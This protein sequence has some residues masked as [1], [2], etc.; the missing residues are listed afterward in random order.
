MGNISSN[1]PNPPNI[2][3]SI[4]KSRKFRDK[5]HEE[6]ANEYTEK[7][8]KHE[9]LKFFADGKMDQV[10]RLLQEGYDP[11]S[12]NNQPLLFALRNNH[13][14]IVELL[15]QNDKVKDKLSKLSE[16][17]KRT[18]DS[19]NITWREQPSNAFRPKKKSA[20]KTKKSAR[21]SPKKSGRTK[22][23]VRKSHKSARKNRK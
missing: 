20:R 6:Q 7:L 5:Q 4:L 3:S 19:L 23:S 9:D 21:K 15:L 13:V 1:S 16:S 10:E 8:I 18:L 2:D 17:D 14:G 12:R 11:S 22:K